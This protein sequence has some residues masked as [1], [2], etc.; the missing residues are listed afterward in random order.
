MLRKVEK[1]EKTRKKGQIEM[2]IVSDDNDH[3]SR[4]WRIFK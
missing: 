3:Y 1:K 2:L 4:E